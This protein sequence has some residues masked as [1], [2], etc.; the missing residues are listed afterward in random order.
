MNKQKTTRHRRKHHKLH[1]KNNKTTKNKKG[2]ANKNAT[3]QTYK[4]TTK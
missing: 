3:L 2:N 1:T 4:N